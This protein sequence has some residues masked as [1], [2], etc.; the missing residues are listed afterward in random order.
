MTERM[1]HALALARQG[2]RI[3]PL[4]P[5]TKEPYKQEGWK[6]IMT[7]NENAIRMWFATRDDM[8]YAVVC[9]TWHV[10]LDP[11]EGVRKDGTKKNG[12]QNFKDAEQADTDAF[13]EESIFDNTFRVRTPKGGVHLYFVSEGAYANAAGENSVIPDVDV[14]GPDGYVV[15][16]GCW[17]FEDLPRQAEGDYVVECDVEPADLPPWLKV[18]LERGGRVGERAKNANTAT[19]KVD[20]PYSIERAKQKLRERRVAEEG[21]AGDLH[22]YVTACCVKDEGISQEKCLDLMFNE[23][24]F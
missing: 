2:F 12:I 6:A 13:V 22:T 8:N 5:G 21:Q 14:R 24:L 17:T 1:E 18:R 15:G 4:R 3:F 16:P 9:D 23:I 11:D 10:I 19:G 20:A 7:T